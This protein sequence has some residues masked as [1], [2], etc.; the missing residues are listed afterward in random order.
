MGLV[1]AG[2]RRRWPG[3]CIPYAW[4]ANVFSDAELASIRWAMEHWEDNAPVH[5]VLRTTQD[6][7]VKFI[8]DPVP[9]DGFCSSNALGMAGGEQQILLDSE[10][11]RGSVVHEIGHALGLVHEH[12]RR[13]RGT[14]V[15]LRM[16]QVKDIYRYQFE[17]VQANEA[18]PIGT[19]DIGSIMHYGPSP[20]ASIDG[21]TDIITP[22]DSTVTNMGQRDALSAGDVTAAQ[23]LTAGNAH[24]YQLTHHGQLEEVVV[25]T[26]WAN[27][28]WRLAIAY[29]IGGDKFLLRLKRSGGKTRVRV[30]RL[31]LDGAVGEQVQSLNSWTGNWTAAV[32]YDISGSNFVLF[33]E[34]AS[35]G[36]KVRKIRSDGTV[37]EAVHEGDIEGG[38]SFATAYTILA[39]N[40]FM[41]SNNGTG[42]IRIYEMTGDGNIGQSRFYN[43]YARKWTTTRPFHVLADTFILMLESSS[44]AVRIR[45]LTYDGKIGEQIQSKSWSSGWR[46]AIPYNVGTSTFLFLLKNGGSL[47]IE[48]IESDGKIGGETDRRV[49]GS[50]WKLVSIYNVGVGTYLLL[51]NPD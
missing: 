40:F 8:P 22:D 42:E 33:Y 16:S 12:K 6:R 34:E 30:S 37:G 31:N 25:Q 20:Q 49:I 10:V 1:T 32:K 44:G 14:F 7:Y 15:N 3:N 43:N 19:Y 45:R 48:R 26:T 38:W 51:I 35:G 27:V 24:V 29:T 39:A 13:D 18:T 2:I 5:F 17:K 9:T 4:D 46:T 36:Y 28:G 21:Q 50:G 23:T 41:F 11:A 47:A